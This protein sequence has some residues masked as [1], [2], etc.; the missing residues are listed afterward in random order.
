MNQEIIIHPVHIGTIN[1]TTRPYMKN[2][3][4]RARRESQAIITLSSYF[5]GGFHLNLWDRERCSGLNVL[6]F[7]TMM[8]KYRHGHQKRGFTGNGGSICQVQKVRTLIQVRHYVRHISKKNIKVKFGY[9]SLINRTFILYKL[10][11]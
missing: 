4:N 5:Q 1:K 7:S 2:A 8:P 11:L 9:G 3:W 10:N 6:K